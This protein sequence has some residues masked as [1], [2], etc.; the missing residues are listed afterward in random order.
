MKSIHDSLSPLQLA[1]AHVHAASA[2]FQARVDEALAIIRQGVEETDGLI[3]SSCSFGKDSAVMTHLALTVNPQMEVRFVYFGN[4]E[5]E[6]L[7]NYAEVLAAWQERYALNLHILTLVRDK[8]DVRFPQWDWL[9]AMRPANGYLVGLRKEES[10]KRRLS[11]LHL[12]SIYRKVNGLLRVAPLLNWRIEDIGAYVVMHDLPMLNSYH[13]EGFDA[14]TTA[15]VP[16]KQQRSLM[17]NRM[18]LT[19]EVAYQQLVLMLPEVETWL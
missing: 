8:L 18:R 19:D 17:L 10:K 6:L 4:G 2:K 5:S 3:Y 7:N 15:S 13:V 16:W 12:G 1:A 9:S 14:R 11:L